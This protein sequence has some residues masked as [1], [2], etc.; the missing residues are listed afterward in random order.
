MN[1]CSF[2]INTATCINV[3][4]KWLIN[5]CA[6]IKLIVTSRLWLVMILYIINVE[7]SSPRVP[8]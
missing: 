7:V 5:V 8:I 4:E 2:S 3:R 6:H 1:K